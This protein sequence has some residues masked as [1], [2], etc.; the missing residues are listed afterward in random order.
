MSGLRRGCLYALAT[1]VLLGISWWLQS[2]I[3]ADG[4]AGFSQALSWL[5]LMGVLLL[6]IGI[7]LRRGGD[8]LFFDGVGG[9]T[10]ALAVLF[11]LLYGGMDTPADA[12]A[13]LAVNVLLCLWTALPV[14][15]GVRTLVLGFS[16][17][18]ACGRRHPVAWLAGALLIVAVLL[19]FT[20]QWLPLIE[21]KPLT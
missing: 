12:G 4:A 19:L 13:V 6:G 3:A 17:E 9:I 8:A 15:F 1:A 14:V 18:A 7:F 16:S 5:L 10:L 2:G 21:M 20:G 11:F